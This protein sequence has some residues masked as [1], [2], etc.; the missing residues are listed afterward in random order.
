MS[1]PNSKQLQRLLIIYSALGLFSFS[2]I[3]AA[4]GIFPLSRQLRKNEEKNLQ[5]KL[6]TR[7]MTVDEFLLRAKDIALQITSRTRARQ[8]LEDYNQGKVQKKE[9]VEFTRKILTDAFNQTKDI[10]GITRLDNRENLIARVGKPIPIQFWQIPSPQ[11][12]EA[13]ISNPIQLNK[14]P[15][16]AIGAPIINPISRERVGTD[17]VLFKLDGLQQIIQDY[18]RSE[19][20]GKIILGSVD[21]DRIEIFFP[22]QNTWKED[23]A[24]RD[25]ALR[26][27]VEWQKTGILKGESH[28]FFAFKPIRENQWGLV[29]KIDAR[30]LYAPVNRHIK[31]VAVAIIIISLLGTGGMIFLLQPLAGKAIVRVDKLKE[32]VHEK[33]LALQQLKQAQVQLI[34]QEKMA[35]LGQLVAGVAHEINNPVSFIYGNIN[36]ARQYIKKLVNL[37]ELYQYYYPQPDR[38]IQNNIEEIELDFIIQDLSNILNSMEMGSDRIRKIVLSLRNFSRLDEAQIKPVDI[39]EGLQST[40][41]ILQSQCQET[42][43]RPEIEIIKQYGELPLVDCYPSLLNQVFL[44]LISNSIDAIEEKYQQHDKEKL[45]QKPTIKIKTELQHKNKIVIYIADNGIGITEEVYP[46]LFEPFFTTKKLGQGTGLGLA[47]SY[48]IIVKQHRGKL[49]CHSQP[50]EGCEFMIEIP[51]HQVS[52]PEKIQ[53]DD[54]QLLK[55][56]E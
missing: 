54:I 23:I 36:H 6:H 27:A 25:R 46:Q 53:I 28:Y 20:T 50:G 56:I 51:I 12:Q 22:G 49:S 45:D 13:K 8:V 31:A 2:T 21:R 44:N 17:I 42:C 38:E 48:A 24:T 9:T 29:A 3:V 43:D 35:T 16:L 4:I 39:N 11:S 55:T 52:S 19:E 18:T 26:N 14:Y 41:M 40:L 34:Q 32:K 10:A 33:T 30:E 5:L 1:P 37:L 7:T 47:I 15:Y